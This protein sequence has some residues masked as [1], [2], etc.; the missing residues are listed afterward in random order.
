MS[1]H[2]TE[3]KQDARLFAIDTPL[4]PNKALLITPEGEDVLSRCFHYRVTIET[5]QSDSAVQS[6]L[7]MP[8]TLWLL[9]DDPEP[10]RPIHGHV[11][12][13]VGRGFTPRGTNLYEL[14]VVPRLWFLSCTSDCRI[15]QNQSIPDIIQTILDEH[16]LI[17]FEFRIVRSDNPPVEYCVQYQ[18]TALDFV[19]R[20]MEHLG[21][22]Y[23]HEHGANKHLLVI[24]DRNM[25]APMCQPAELRMSP[26]SGVDEI[27]SLDF[28]CTFRPGKWALN[29]YDFQSPTRLLR[30]DSPTTLNVPRMV[31]HEM[32]EY[33][34]K[35]IDQESGKHLSRLRIEMEES[36]HRR[37]F[38]T[39]RCA[40]FDPGRRFAVSATRGGRPT[41]YLLTKVR[42]H[43][44][45][46]GAETAGEEANYTN[47]YVAIPVDLPFRPERLTPKPFVR[48]TQ[49]ATVVGPPGENIYCDQ[50]GRVR[51]QFHWDRRGQR[52]D[53]SSCWMRVAQAR[54]GSNYGTLVIPHVG[55][56]VLISFIEGDPDRPLIIGTV[57]NALTMPPVN[58]PW[59]KDKTVQRDHGHNK[60]V[61]QGKAGKESTSVVSPRA[62]NLFA[63]G[64]TAKPLSAAASN[65]QYF[66][67][68]PTDN[69]GISVTGGTTSITS[70]QTSPT[71]GTTGQYFIS[72]YKDSTGLQQVWYEW[73]GTVMSDVAVSGNYG[74]STASGTPPAFSVDPNTGQV[75]SSSGTVTTEATLSNGDTIYNI[76][77]AGAEWQITV[78]PTV[79]VTTT[80][81]DTLIGDIPIPTS[82]TTYGTP[83]AVP[84]T[85]ASGTYGTQDGTAAGSYLNW[86]SE[87]RINCVVLSNNNLWV[88]ADANTWINGNVNTQING[89]STTVIGGAQYTEAGGTNPSTATT[90]IWGANI[91]EVMGDNTSTVLGSNNSFVGI[92]N[93]SVVIGLNLSM[94][95]GE[96]F[97]LNVGGINTVNIGAFNTTTNIGASANTYISA[98]I[99][100]HLVIK[101]DDSVTKIQTA[102][103]SIKEAAAAINTEDVQMDEATAKLITTASMIVL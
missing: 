74:Y 29:D 62:V 84:V 33:P 10:R 70:G 85:S 49:T 66:S 40:G 58:L 72:N 57:P 63:S 75:A 4:G 2:A 11:R 87:G 96:N 71:S 95:V 7:G 97:S 17:D 61:M 13:L 82:Q 53:R 42:H 36:Q 103:T 64:R 94:V 50:Y 35:F 77:S 89:D 43:G 24:A 69:A 47:D 44:T 18:E 79:T 54:S 65:G 41:T 91:A 30:V 60:I 25:A 81:V 73:F 22:F 52:N 1:D 3:Y 59:D 83:T 68:D 20:W 99:D 34:G 23:W 9:N 80:Y 92:D 14:D 78:Q 48:G 45:A 12:R 101:S 55:H 102:L 46:P 76:S 16:G 38:G 88:Y 98:R 56:E 27:Q 21:L 26:M 28:E 31:N 19:S 8:V 90:T 6:L 39:G 37:V 51:V 67:D 15:F 93:T 86:G 32:Y 100:G 5:E